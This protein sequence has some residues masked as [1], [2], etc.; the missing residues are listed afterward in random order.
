MKEPFVTDIAGLTNETALIGDIQIRSYISSLDEADKLT[1][2]RGNLQTANEGILAGKAATYTSAINQ[3]TGADNNITSA[4]YYLSRTEDLAT[5]V[6][7]FDSANQKQLSVSMINQGL[8]KRQKEINE[9]SNL[10]KLDTLY[11]MQ[12]LFVSLS[13]CGFLAFLSANGT[14][15]SYLFAFVSYIIGILAIIVLIL[16]WRYTYLGRDSRYWHKARF[17]NEP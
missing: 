5:A 9:W 17:A 14:I 13:L 11:F 16:R 15:S 3:V 10:N 1:Y 8:N 2:I 12:V 6:G 7:D 4:A